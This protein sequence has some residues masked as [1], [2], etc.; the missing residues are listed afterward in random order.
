MYPFD[1][2]IKISRKEKNR[3]QIIYAVSC[4][5]LSVTFLWGFLTVYVNCYNIMN[6]EPMTVL[7]FYRS[8]EGFSATVLGKDYVILH[9]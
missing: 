6:A 4:I 3:R 9:F 7:D 2:R 5:I 1:F 8:E